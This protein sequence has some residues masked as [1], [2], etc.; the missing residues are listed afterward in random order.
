MVSFWRGGWCDAF[1][2][3]GGGGDGVVRFWRGG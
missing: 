2:G 1:L 3:E